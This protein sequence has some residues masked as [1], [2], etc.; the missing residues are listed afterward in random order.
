M[1]KNDENYIEFHD[2]NTYIAREEYGIA[3]KLL[4]DGLKKAYS[5]SDNSLA[6]FYS[7]AIGHVYLLMGDNKKARPYYD[8]AAELSDTYDTILNYARILLSIYNDY[9]NAL[10]EAKKTIYKIPP[11]DQALNNAY[12]IIGSC[13]LR[14]NKIDEALNAFSLSMEVDFTT[15]DSSDSY[16]LT[17]ANSLI[18]RGIINSAVIDY[19][20]HIRK[21][22]LKENN[23]HMLEVIERLLKS[24]R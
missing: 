23:D 11:R 22:A 6:S 24:S 13:Y 21:I 9:Q 19:L 14:M 1:H 3:I 16:D 4:N 15:F 7:S 17:L 18:E 2:A 8:R 10:E 5:H 12:S 20:H